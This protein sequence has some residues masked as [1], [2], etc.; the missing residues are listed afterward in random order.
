MLSDLSKGAYDYKYLLGNLSSG[1]GKN[2][3]AEFDNNLIEQWTE[4]MLGRII[5]KKTS[6]FKTIIV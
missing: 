4:K 5:L 3:N 6:I 2:V 1:S